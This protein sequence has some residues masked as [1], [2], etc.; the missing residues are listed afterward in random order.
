MHIKQ[1][2]DSKEV[3]VI[4]IKNTINENMVHICKYPFKVDLKCEHE[5][6][7]GNKSIIY[8]LIDVTFPNPNTEYTEFGSKSAYN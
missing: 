2:F 1:S 3:V 6:A 4:E 7:A 5:F 8:R